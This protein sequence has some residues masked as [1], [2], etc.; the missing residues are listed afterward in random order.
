MAVQ[1]RD[2]YEVLGLPR[3]AEP[4][5]IKKAFKKL[6][7]EYHPDV[8][9]DEEEAEEKFKEINEAYEVLSDP[10]K[11]EKYDLLGENWQHGADFTPPPGT[12]GFG[13]DSDGV[14]YEYHFDG[15]TGFSDFFENLFGG[16]RAGDP[17]GAWSSHPGSRGSRPMRGLDF[18]SDLLVALME[19]IEGGERTI[20][21]QSSEAGAIKTVKVKIPKGVA[22]NQLIRCAGLGGE[23]INGGDRGDL[24]LRIRYERHPDFRTEG[25]DVFGDIE[26]PPWDLVLGCQRRVKTPLGTV[27][28]KI[29]PH[30]QPGTR[31][32]VKNHGLPTTD[33]KTGDFYLEVHSITPKKLTDKQRELWEE[34][35]RESSSDET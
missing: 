16:R 12:G 8:A 9:E 25:A 10:E 14:H 2:Y 15:S 26:L 4:S 30:S 23:G 1:F 22:E 33:G 35:A 29:P 3:D 27:R 6:A 11:R 34:I 17:F 7:R 18:E 13:F 5:A 21:L 24:F 19:V 32:R 20:R 28:M 31:L